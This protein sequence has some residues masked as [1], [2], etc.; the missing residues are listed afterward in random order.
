MRSTLSFQCIKMKKKIKRKEM[1]GWSV[2]YMNPPKCAFCDSELQWRNLIND[3]IM[4]FVQ[5]M[6]KLNARQS[7]STTIDWWHDELTAAKQKTKSEVCMFYARFV[8]TG[9]SRHK[10]TKSITD[11]NKFIF[12]AIRNQ[13]KNICCSH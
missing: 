5:S 1:I 8:L 7:V 11:Q 13:I 2:Q 4:Q 3:G 9:N 6:Q 10:K 12:I